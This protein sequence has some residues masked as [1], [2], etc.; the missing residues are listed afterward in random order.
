VKTRCSG[1]GKVQTRWS[2]RC[3][4]AGGRARDEREEEGKSW[5]N[6]TKACLL[7]G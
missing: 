7:L 2:W 6:E 3:D 1:S 5:L 4:S